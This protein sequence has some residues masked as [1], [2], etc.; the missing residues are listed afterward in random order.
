MTFSQ[1]TGLLRKNSL[2]AELAAPIS[3]WSE[4]KP[5]SNHW[6]AHRGRIN[7]MRLAI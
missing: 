2:S 3:L 4:A 5:D 6:A 7:G 1:D